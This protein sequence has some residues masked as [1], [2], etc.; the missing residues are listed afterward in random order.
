MIAD[1]MRGLA[2]TFSLYSK[3][4]MPNVEWKEENMKYVM[5][6]FPLVGIVHGLLW[7]FWW[8]LCSKI[9]SVI[10]FRVL[11][12]SALPF[13]LDGGIHFDGFLDVCDAL[14]SYSDREKKLEILK[15]PH[16]GA[17]AV[18]YAMIYIMLWIAAVSL[19]ERKD[20][21]IGGVVFCAARALSS[22]TFV[23][24]NSA[25]KDGMQNTVSKASDKKLVQITSVLYLIV[26]FL[27]IVFESP[28]KAFMFLLVGA[29]MTFVYHHMAYKNFGGITGDTAGWY[30]E[31]TTLAMFFVI[32]LI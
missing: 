10:L 6:F 7:I 13:L 5:C 27:A 21:F 22:I 8:I 18:I 9:S 31:L 25:K 1:I 26:C 15:D 28:Y 4:P 20:I 24:F 29:A 12:C 30:F 17:F 16:I 23:S 19:I 11:T 32:G 3:I 14:H 2:M